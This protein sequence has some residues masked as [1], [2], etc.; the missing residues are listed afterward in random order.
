MFVP[1]INPARLAPTLHGMMTPFEQLEDYI[2]ATLKNYGFVTRPKKITTVYRMKGQLFARVVI[3]KN[4]CS[5]FGE[6]EDGGHVYLFNL[7]KKHH[8]SGPCYRQHAPKY[9]LALF[10]KSTI[11]VIQI[12]YQK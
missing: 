8:S 6:S 11:T 10:L 9:C 4:V 1:D 7:I 12:C 2:A 3:G 5:F